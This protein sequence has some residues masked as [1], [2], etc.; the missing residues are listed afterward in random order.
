L[1]T[2]QAKPTVATL[3]GL[4]QLLSCAATHP[5]AVMMRFHAS[6]MALRIGD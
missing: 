4:V 5:D 3:K 1:A 2:Q 6:D